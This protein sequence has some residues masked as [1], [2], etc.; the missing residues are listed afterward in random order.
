MK[1]TNFDILFEKVITINEGR[2]KKV[3]P[4]FTLNLD[5]LTEDLKN[6]KS[7][8]KNFY[9]QAL[10]HV[11]STGNLPETKPEWESTINH[12]FLNQGLG[13]DERKLL[14]KRFW[15]VLNTPDHSYFVEFDENAANQEEQTKSISSV[16]EHIYNYIIESDDEA[17]TKEEVKAYISKYG[18]EEE[19][20]DK[21]IN[22]MIADGQLGEE[23]GKLVAI[24]DPSL[25]ELEAPES[26]DNTDD[27]ME[28]FRTDT[29]SGDIDSLNTDSSIS[30][31]ID[32][33]TAKDLGI[34]MDDP[35]GEKGMLDD[36]YNDF[37]K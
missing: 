24:K 1:K 27:E 7:P 17:A 12:G 18:H 11:Q 30:H 33:E 36:N 19:E 5:K 37:D 8:F 35:W 2:K 21:I 13:P 22:K 6:L 34:D 31:D 32:P 25:D 28:A 29:E 9:L 23:N 10:Q 14:F 15:H 3:Y 4:K 20:V 26:F 16:E